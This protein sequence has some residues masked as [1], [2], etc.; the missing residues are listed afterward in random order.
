LPLTP[1]AAISNA[2]LAA[3]PPSFDWQGTDPDEVI[4]EI[5]QDYIDEFSEIN[6]V[7]S[8]AYIICCVEWLYYFVRDNFQ[9]EEA[10]R[11]EQHILA[12][13][14]WVHDLPRKSP[15]QF[16]VDKTRTAQE[17]SVFN[18]AVEVAL[19]SIID[20]IA[21]VPDAETAVDAAFVTQLCEYVLPTE[22]EFGSWKNVVVQRLKAEF[23][24][25]AMHYDVVQVSRR[26]FDTDVDAEKIN[27]AAD[28]IDPPEDG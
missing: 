12:N 26:I 6:D 25:G 1:I 14:V 9:S 21:S 7:A 22:C 18:D 19:E 5:N 3:P 27:H 8:V 28:V 20:G 11:Y 23:P 17:R 2:I 24:A 13:W 15:P 16:A 10:A 4:G